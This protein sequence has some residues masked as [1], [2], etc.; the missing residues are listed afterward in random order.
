MASPASA[1]QGNL[2]NRRASQPS[3]SGHAA[4]APVRFATRG[5][6]SSVRTITGSICS[7]LICRRSSDTPR[8]PYTRTARAGQGRI[9]RNGSVRSASEKA[10]AQKPS[11]LRFDEA[12][13]AA[14][15]G[16]RPLRRGRSRSDRVFW[17]SSVSALVLRCVACVFS[18]P[19]CAVTR[20]QTERR[21]YCLRNRP[22]CDV[23]HAV[24]L[25]GVPVTDLAAGMTALWT[26]I[27]HVIGGLD[28]V[29]VVLDHDH[30]VTRVA[31]VI[32]RSSNRSMSAGQPGG[33]LV[34]GFRPCASPAGAVSAPLQSSGRCGSPPGSVVADPSI[35][36]RKYHDCRDAFRWRPRQPVTQRRR[37]RPRPM[38][39]GARLAAVGVA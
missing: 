1:R 15:R 22:V 23:L 10:A 38:M 18:V 25:S 37:V 13:Q 20:H 33:R 30:S 16:R 29:E 27:D 19:R 11:K 26:K 36:L 8:D 31:Q 35:C 4:A 21:R 6:A 32:E 39:S 28:H 14:A 24:T 12:R 17:S 5:V 2:L 7:S 3:R 9:D 34:K